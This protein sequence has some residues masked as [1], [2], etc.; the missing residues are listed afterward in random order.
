MKGYKIERNIKQIGY[1][2]D[3]EPMLARIFLLAL[4]SFLTVDHLA[5]LVSIDIIPPIIICDL[6]PSKSRNGKTVLVTPT[7]TTRSKIQVVKKPT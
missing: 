5:N 4:V 1:W 7:I 6:T 2:P 3:Y